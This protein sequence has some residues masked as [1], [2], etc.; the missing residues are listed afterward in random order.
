MKVHMKEKEYNPNLE[1]YRKCYHCLKLYDEKVEH[2]CYQVNRI[3]DWKKPRVGKKD[4]KI[5]GPSDDALANDLNKS[6]DSNT[7][8][9]LNKSDN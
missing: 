3:K 6:S 2:T 4:R 8:S 5:H 9:D 7:S 1:G